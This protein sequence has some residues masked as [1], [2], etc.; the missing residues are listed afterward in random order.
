MNP[1]DP[2]VSRDLLGRL[3]DLEELPIGAA[4]PAWMDN[5]N[6]GPAISLLCKEAR[7]EI[8]R[9]RQLAGAVSAGPSFSEVVR[10]VGR[11]RETG[12]EDLK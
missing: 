4:A 2:A 12:H 7:Q 1:Y 6:W 5:N 9:L 3:R 10:D 11:F 8:E